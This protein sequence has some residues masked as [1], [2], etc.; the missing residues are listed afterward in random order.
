MG[1]N[2]NSHA[3]KQQTLFQQITE[4]VIFNVLNLF[5]IGFLSVMW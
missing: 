2:Q 1:Y 4:W 5:L 3:I